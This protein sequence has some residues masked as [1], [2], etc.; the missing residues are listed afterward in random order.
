MIP[1]WEAFLLMPEPSGIITMVRFP[2][3]EEPPAGI[4]PEII[5]MHAEPAGRKSLLADCRS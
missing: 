5:P 4:P 1:D 2:D 3:L